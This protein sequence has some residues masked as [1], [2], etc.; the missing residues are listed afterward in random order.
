MTTDDELT[1]NVTQQPK[2]TRKKSE[3]PGSRQGP[4]ITPKSEQTSASS[5]GTS[6]E[7]TGMVKSSKRT[8]KMDQSPAEAQ[9]EPQNEPVPVSLWRRTRLLRSILVFLLFSAF[10]LYWSL[11]T[12]VIPTIFHSKSNRMSGEWNVA[13]AGFTNLDTDLRRADVNLIGDVFSNRFIQEME[14]LG[15]N[16]NLV[17]QVWGPEK[18]KLISGDDAEK[19]ASEAEKL[20]NEIN[21]DMIIY[22]SIQQI[23]D[24]YVLQPEFYVRAENY[25]EA[26]EL[27]GQHRFGGP[28]SILA[29]RDTL[30]SQVQLNIELARR[31]KILAL[32][33]RGLSL[34]LL[35]AYD[36]ASEFFTQA[37]QDDLWPNLMGRETIYLFQAN[38]DIKQQQLEPAK[39][40]LE[41]AI[42]ISPDYGRGYI[43]LGI[44]NYLHASASGD[45][46]SFNPDRQD[47]AQ[48][49]EFFEQALR[50]ADIQPASAEIP[51]K[52]TFGLGQIYLTNWFLGDESHDQ[53]VESF[54]KVIA[55][56]ADGA[57]P[58]LQELASESHARLAVIYRQDGQFEPAM[59]E[60]QQALNLSTLPARKGLYHASIG[61]LYRQKGDTQQ[62]ED[63]S[64]QSIIAYQ[65]ALE[66][67]ISEKL[68]AFYWA[69]IAE[70]YEFLQEIP[71]AMNAYEQALARL[72]VDSPEYD[73]YQQRLKELN[74]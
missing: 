35:S 30:P 16:A 51:S 21:A 66:L 2:S 42:K 41:Q 6:I 64:N 5:A 14:G 20:A 13:V 24:S 56:Y 72:P 73:A 12:D 31:S 71:Q 36:Q 22:G 10:P 67:P 28:I 68:R 34:Y 55:E 59:S 4:G 57:K 47:L 33:A 19:R 40:A 39:I 54:Q 9:A 52:A 17:V 44:V 61:A 62:A 32:V 65:K 69:K 63:S 58:Q 27:V 48:A 37:N 15:N 26:D 50:I 46:L 38:A 23:D 7:T 25:Y 49:K 3:K 60:F 18:V 1:N 70:Q 8:K 11:T 74:P 53:A 45:Q 43:G 29:T